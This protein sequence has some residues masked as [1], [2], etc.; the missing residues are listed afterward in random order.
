MASGRSRGDEAQEAVCLCLYAPGTALGWKN[1]KRTGLPL[2][3]GYGGA[4][5]TNSRRNSPFGGGRRLSWHGGRRHGDGV[6][7]L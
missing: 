6:A 2:V 7:T 4:S 1:A 3:G 5:S